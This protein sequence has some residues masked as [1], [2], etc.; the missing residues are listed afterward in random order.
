MEGPECENLEQRIVTRK[1]YYKLKL[2][3]YQALCPFVINEKLRVMTSN[4]S[5]YTFEQIEYDTQ[6]I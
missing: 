6:L 1:H 4:K 5:I 2:V 3:N